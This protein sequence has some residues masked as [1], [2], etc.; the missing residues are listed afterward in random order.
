MPGKKE[1]ASMNNQLQQLR[2]I[3]EETEALL[4][5]TQPKRTHNIS[6]DTSNSP[7][8]RFEG[9]AVGDAAVKMVMELRTVDES[10]DSP[11]KDDAMLVAAMQKALERMGYSEDEKRYRMYFNTLVRGYFQINGQKDVMSLKDVLQCVLF[12]E[13]STQNLIFQKAGVYFNICREGLPDCQEIIRLVIE[14]YPNSPTPNAA[15]ID[16]YKDSLRKAIV[17]LGEEDRTGKK[18]WEMKNGLQMLSAF[19]YRMKPTV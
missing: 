17:G 19:V 7:R 1:M 3:L 4:K 15:S 14:S 18:F 2:R 9:G 8:A 10:G 16:A 12:L 13:N 6:T 11:F 5:S